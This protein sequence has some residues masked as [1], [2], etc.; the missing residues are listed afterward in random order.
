[1]PLRY[2]LGFMLGA[3]TV[4]AFGVRTPH[5]FGHVGLSNIFSWADPDRRLAVAL[6]TSGKPSFS[7]DVIRLFS[8]L[9]EIGRA[10]PPVR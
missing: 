5:A 6:I 3:E 2:G 8:V 9:L 4:S 10:F 1:M 7:L